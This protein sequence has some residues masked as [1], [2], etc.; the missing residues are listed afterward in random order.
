MDYYIFE[1]AFKTKR[2]ISSSQFSVEDICDTLTKQQK[3]NRTIHEF[4]KLQISEDKI[5]NERHS[6]K[7]LVTK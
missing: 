3:K 7:M 4:L 2:N 1:T 5:D 6:N